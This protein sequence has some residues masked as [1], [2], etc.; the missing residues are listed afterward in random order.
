MIRPLDTFE[1]SSDNIPFNSLFPE[2]PII[3][4]KD[5]PI[6]KDYLPPELR[7]SILRISNI[8]WD[9]S[10]EDIIIMFESLKI[11]HE[12]VHIPIDR[13]SG[14]TKGEIFI[15]IKNIYDCFKAIELYDKRILKGRSLVLSLSS[16]P[17]LYNS[18]FSGLGKFS[19]CESQ[20]ITVICR[21]YKVPKYL[22]K[23][24]SMLFG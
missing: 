12:H 19:Q 14:K 1:D 20:K 17:E 9:T 23:L 16:Y 7:Q 22:I 8:S 6:V 21:N 3:H 18:M 5:S 10:I 2:K 24:D 15:E 13:E 11:K 4:L